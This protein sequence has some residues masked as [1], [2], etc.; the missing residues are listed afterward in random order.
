MPRGEAP[1]CCPPRRTLC[2]SSDPPQHTPSRRRLRSVLRRPTR[3]PKDAKT[4]RPPARAAT[5][6][7][8]GFLLPVLRHRAQAGGG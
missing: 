1:L 2:G 5:P 8:E 7:P 4:P 6:C 3:G